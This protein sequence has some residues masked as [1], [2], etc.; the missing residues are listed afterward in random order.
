[1][2]LVFPVTPGLPYAIEASTSATGPWAV[3]ETGT[4]TEVAG[5]FVYPV[6]SSE[7]GRFFRARSN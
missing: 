1:L 4:G 2:I 7:R 5:S 6:L 3:V